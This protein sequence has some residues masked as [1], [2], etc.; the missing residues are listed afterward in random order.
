VSTPYAKFLGVK[1]FDLGAAKRRRGSL[2]NPL[3]ICRALAQCLICHI[4]PPL[5]KCILLLT[6]LTGNDNQSS[7][8]HIFKFLKKDSWKNIVSKKAE[9]NYN[10]L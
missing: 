2:G 7:L 9:I 10:Y 4:V 6:L 5:T 8:L 1:A 3:T